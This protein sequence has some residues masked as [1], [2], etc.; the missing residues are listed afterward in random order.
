M[1]YLCKRKLAL[2]FKAWNSRNALSKE[3]E[4]L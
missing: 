3:K 1:K 4:L 2:N